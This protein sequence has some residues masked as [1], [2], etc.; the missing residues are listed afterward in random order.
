[1]NEHWNCRDKHKRAPLVSVVV[2]TYN[3]EEFIAEAVTSILQQEYRLG[4]VE[5]LVIDDGSRDG[6][7]KQ[8]SAFADRVRIVRKENGGQASALNLGV[9]L[10][11]GDI[12]AFLD[13]DDW[14]H[15]RK[16]QAVVGYLLRDPTVGMVGHGIV[17]VA[18][19]GTQRALTP[20]KLLR[21]DLKSESGPATFKQVTCFLGT[22]RLTCRRSVLERLLPIPE[23][24]VIEADEYLFT[25]GSAIAEVAVL[26]KPLCYYRLH[27][28]N[29]YQFGDYDPARLR[30]KHSVVAEL[31]K[32]LPQKLTAL[33][34]SDAN[35]SK[36][37]ENTT[38]DA[39]R[40]G[41]AIHGGHIGTAF[42]VEWA[43]MRA[44]PEQWPLARW[45]VKALM[46]LLALILPPKLFYR[47]RHRYSNL[48]KAAVI[49][50]ITAWRARPTS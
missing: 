40:L 47:L 32:A 21:F 8:L 2:D 24:L 14:W 50:P 37:V 1:M 33:G 3:H 26:D 25:L 39:R 18:A 22:S 41:L 34:V 30:R 23:A 20:G 11:R 28:N 5:V 38:R 17:E 16:L 49:S 27:G 45:P 35:I 46:L 19:D 10:A 31:A 36:V 29:L 42:R 12:I 43:V 6:T 48:R 15:P 44:H 7:A 13:G 4:A 9:G